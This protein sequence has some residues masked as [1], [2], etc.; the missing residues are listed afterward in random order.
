[1]ESI[2]LA[3][4]DYHYILFFLIFSMHFVYF[5]ATSNKVQ[6]YSIFCSATKMLHSP[7]II[8]FLRTVRHMVLV[9][10]LLCLK[11]NNNV[12]KQLLQ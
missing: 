9:V 4:C 8:T 3:G 11:N 2:A 5:S 10:T 1:M 6:Q 7:C 12:E